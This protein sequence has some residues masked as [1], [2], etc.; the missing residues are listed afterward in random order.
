MK[1]EEITEKRK[2]FLEDVSHTGKFEREPIYSPYFYEMI[3]DGCA[4][5]E[6]YLGEGLPVYS[7]FKITSEDREIFPELKSV[8]GVTCWESG[9]GFFNCVDLET[10]EDFEAEIKNF[11][12]Q[13]E[14]MDENEE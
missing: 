5:E 12:R 14:E 4:G 11:E 10:K 13:I 3:L 8:Y 2:T 6:F 1:K 9:Q 7:V